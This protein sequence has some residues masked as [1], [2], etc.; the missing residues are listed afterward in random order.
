MNWFDNLKVRCFPPVARSAALDIARQSLSHSALQ[1]SLV[2][3]GQKPEN[4]NIYAR[5]SE[6]CWWIV[7]P[8]GDGKDDLML[9][10]RV[11]AVGRQTGKV[12]YDGS[13]GDEG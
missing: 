2:C 3:H 7:A 4:F 6:P 11:I 13:A 10:S 9:R 5:F 8:W 1:A 12:Y